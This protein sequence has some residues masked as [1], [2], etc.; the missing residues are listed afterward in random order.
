MNISLLNFSVPSHLFHKHNN[1]RKLHQKPQGKK[2]QGLKYRQHGPV[3]CCA[4]IL[5]RKRLQ[6]LMCYLEHF[7]NSFLM[8]SN[9]VFVPQ[10]RSWMLK[11]IKNQSILGFTFRFPLPLPALR[12]LTM[13]SNL[14]PVFPP[15][16][17]VS[18]RNADPYFPLFLL[19]P[20]FFLLQCSFPLSSMPILG[21]SPG[22]HQIDETLY[23]K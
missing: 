11:I 21:H 18:K 23:M 10:F 22:F 1:R 16:V 20:L 7:T 13:Q 12:N 8:P 19:F 6:A 15:F 14:S 2:M 3:L 5:Y 4:N 17:L 9:T